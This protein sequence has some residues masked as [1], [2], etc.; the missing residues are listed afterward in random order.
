MPCGKPLPAACS[1][2]QGS[3]R[4]SGIDVKETDGGDAELTY[5]PLRLGNAIRTMRQ[6][7]MAMEC[8]YFQAK[9]ALG[10]S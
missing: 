6:G 5:R 9:L 1:P 3:D 7:R 8:F 2:H 4:R 10:T